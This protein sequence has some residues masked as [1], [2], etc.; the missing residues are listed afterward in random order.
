MNVSSLPAASANCGWLDDL[1]ELQ[2]IPRVTGRVTAPFVILGAGFTGLSAARRLAEHFP[3]RQIVL[4]DALGIGT[5]TSARSSGF[6]V[7]LGHFDRDWKS[8]NNTRLH[9]LGCAGIRLLKRHVDDYQIRCD[10]NEQGR[11]IGAKSRWAARTLDKICRVLDELGSPWEKLAGEAI[12]DI[13]GMTGYRAAIRQGDSVLVQPAALLRGLA[14]NLPTNVQ[15]Y[16]KSPVERIRMGRSAQLVCPDGCI[17]AGTLLVTVNAYIGALGLATHKV[18]PVRTFASL[19]RPAKVDSCSR[20]FGNQFW[21]I[22]SAERIGSSLRRLPGDRIMIRNTATYGYKARNTPRELERVA[23][24]HAKTLEKRFPETGSLRIHKTW[25]GVIGVTANGWGVFGKLTRN[26][27]AV[28]GH[29]GHGIAHGAIAG[30][31]LADLV[32]GKEN[33]LLDDIQNLPSPAWVPRGPLR[34]AGVGATISFLNWR[35]RKEI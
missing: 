11:L 21:G 29:N 35:G 31:L 27:W 28:A 5:G 32:A 34:R 30:Q 24:V 7:S 12:A 17:E 33:P 23:T 6:V 25:G 19:A 13:T 9:R 8:N 1:T 18:F 22:T 10:W 20:R 2:P 16:E 15:I 4:V 3:G 14:T 26:I